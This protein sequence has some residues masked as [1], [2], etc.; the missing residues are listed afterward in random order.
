M[1]CVSVYTPGKGVDPRASS[2]EGRVI[3]LPY[4]LDLN[5]M[6]PYVIRPNYAMKREAQLCH[7]NGFQDEISPDIKK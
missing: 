7:T 3:A 4:P 1:F 5:S 2:E 6:Q